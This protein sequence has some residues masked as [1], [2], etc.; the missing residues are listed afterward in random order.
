MRTTK[1]QIS[2]RI[3]AVWSA[4][5]LFAALIVWYVHLLYPKFQDSNILHQFLYPQNTPVSSELV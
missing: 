5:L 1:M 3:G 2:L 4:P